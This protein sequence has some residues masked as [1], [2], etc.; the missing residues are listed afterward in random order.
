MDL[1]GARK[2]GR[3]VAVSVVANVLTLLVV[4]LGA[5]AGGYLKVNRWLIS[6]S[7]LITTVTV[8]TL[9]ADAVLRRLWRRRRTR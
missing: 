6:L 5:V 3:D 1:G 4:Y 7:V 9:L 2:F 8:A